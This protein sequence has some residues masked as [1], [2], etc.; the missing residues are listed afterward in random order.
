[1]LGNER[2]GEAAAAGSSF[3]CVG[4][5]GVALPEELGGGDGGERT[6]T[7][8][9]LGWVDGQWWGWTRVK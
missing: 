9:V 2:Y 7:T 8:A 6:T 4:D 3:G 5:E 1:M